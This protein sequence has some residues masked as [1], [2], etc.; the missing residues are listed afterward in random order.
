[1]WEE[2]KPIMVLTQQIE[3]VEEHIA[4][5]WP[6]ALS[7]AKD[8]PP[9]QKNIS[10]VLIGGCG[11][12]H[13][14]ALGLEFAFS[15][16]TGNQAYAMESM[17]LA[18][19]APSILRT[20]P[21]LTLVVGIS[22]SGE[23]ARTIEALEIWRELGAQ[24]LAITTNPDGTLANVADRS[25][26]LAPPGFPH[27]P[28]LLSYIGSL[29]MG[30]AAV[31]WLS[32]QDEHH[33]LNQLINQIPGLLQEW[34]QTERRRGE[35]FAD[36]VEDGITV[37]LGSG[38]AYGS[39]KFGAAKVIEASGERCWAQDVEEWAHLEYFCD[40]AYMPT[41]VLSAEGR[42]NTRELELLKAMK[43]LGRSV[44]LSRWGGHKGW[45]KGER[46]ALSPLA[47]WV[48]PSAYASKRAELLSEEP[49]RGF[50]GG[51]D[52]LEGGGASRIRSSQRL[53]A[54]DFKLP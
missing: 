44:L 47:L 48:A 17:R 43:A 28:G 24:T 39:A 32:G 25:L 49:F 1:M 36:I 21:E 2:M 38:A 54:H 29:L 37:F 33:R 26:V 13:H 23:V 51:R 5:Q 10:Q 53:S 35:A 15:L 16:C 52:R 11:D 4:T 18:R 50:S 40:P 3:M 46:E 12:S 9:L 41:F 14:A 6:I 42:S 27:E 34:V 30:Y 22:S 20:Q 7:Y 45:T 8:L 31:A 19:Y